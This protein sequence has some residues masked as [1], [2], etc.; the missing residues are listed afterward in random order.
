MLIRNPCLI[1]PFPLV[2]T[3]S[4]RKMIRFAYQVIVVLFP[5]SYI[6]VTMPEVF[7]SIQQ[8]ARVLLGWL[9]EQQSTHFL[10]GQRIDVQL[11]D[12]DRER[13]RR[14]R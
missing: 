3:L 4:Q 6:F 14:A 2:T 8:P 11:M 7:G 1:G 13:V 10:T 12:Q 9:D 5:N